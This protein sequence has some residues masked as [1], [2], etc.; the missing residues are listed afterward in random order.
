MTAFKASGPR[1]NECFQDDSMKKAI[2]RLAVSP[3][4]KAKVS[5]CGS[6]F[7]MDARFKFFPFIKHRRPAPARPNATVIADAVAWKAFNA[8]VCDC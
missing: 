2:V 4:F 7:L 8:F 1:A 6:S 3:E 5:A